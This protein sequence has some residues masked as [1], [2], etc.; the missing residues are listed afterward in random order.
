MLPII[1]NKN[2]ITSRNNLIKKKKAETK[3]LNKLKQIN[4]D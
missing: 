4:E 3:I 2:N 1:A